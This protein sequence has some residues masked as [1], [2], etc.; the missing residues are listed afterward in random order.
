ML[1]VLREPRVVKHPR[2]NSYPRRHT[3][4]NSPH[5]KPRI[6]RAHRQELLQTLIVSLAPK[7]RDHRLKR[8]PGPSSNNPRK[9][10]SPFTSCT[11]RFTASPNTSP[12]E[13]P[14]TLT[15]HHRPIHH[16]LHHR[17]DTLLASKPRHKKI[18]QTTHKPYNKTNK[19]LLGP[20]SELERVSSQSASLEPSACRFRSWPFF[21]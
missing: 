18:R 16:R 19:A 20:S 7:P 12:R 17:H 6:P 9:Y 15:H 2:L 14:Q 8:L 1:P 3:L 11:C 4:S 21:R 10:R 5:H 13:H